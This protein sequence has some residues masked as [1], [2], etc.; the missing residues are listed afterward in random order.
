MRQNISYAPS[1]RPALL[2]IGLPMSSPRLGIKARIHAGFGL[3]VALGLAQATFGAW[4]LS[5]IQA[6]VTRMN[7][8]SERGTRALELNRE[9]EVMRRTAQGFHATGDEAQVNLGTEAAAAALELLHQGPL[10]P[11]SS[12]ERRRI[13][14]DIE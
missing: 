7:R 9:L 10:R 1:D 12:K 11:N 3:L 2:I 4:Q 14:N 5:W 8:V 13:Y 6:E